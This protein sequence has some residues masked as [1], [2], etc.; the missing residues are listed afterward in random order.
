M[1]SKLINRRQFLTLPL[2]AILGS[3]LGS[4]LAPLAQALAVADIRQAAYVADVDVLYG[5]LSF[6]LDGTITEMVDRAAGRYDVRAVG[7]GDGIANQMESHGALRDGRWQPLR[8]RTWLSVKGRESRSAITYD[9]A[10]RTIEY[11]FRGETF[12]LRRVR[13]ADDVVPIPDGLRVDDA[14]SAALNYDDGTWRPGPDGTLETWVVRRKRNENEG[15]DD[16]EKFYR[17]ELVPFRLKL[18]PATAS[19][20]P[21]AEFDLTRFSS[22]ATRDR[23]ARVT[24]GRDRRPESMVLSMI[25]GTS[26][27]IQL[28]TA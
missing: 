25:L 8:L 9:Y 7:E 18:I 24:F 6:R 4:A 11:R 27:R 28:K 22:W 21:V 2:A 15:P 1:S 16:V 20:K 12:L 13:V 26:V 19:G 14:V 10:R 5:L 17:A 23:P 3:A